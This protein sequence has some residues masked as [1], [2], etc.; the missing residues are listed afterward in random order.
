VF[1]II[2]TEIAYK[3]HMKIL[4]AIH[5]YKRNMMLQ[6]I[7][8]F[9]VDYDDMESLETTVHRLGDFG[10]ENILPRYQFE[11]IKDYIF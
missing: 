8:K 9:E 11:I 4:D 3:N 5:R 7:Y 2:K 1:L 10:Y 6:G